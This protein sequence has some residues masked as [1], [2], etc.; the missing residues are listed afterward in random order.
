MRNRI[1][2]V[3]LIVISII[4]VAFGIHAKQTQEVRNCVVQTYVTTPDDSLFPDTKN[5]KSLADHLRVAL[6]QEQSATTRMVQYR[7]SSDNQKAA[8][9]EL[10]EEMMKMIDQC[11]SEP[12][13]INV[14][15]D[16]N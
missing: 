2:I 13:C 7:A 8:Y 16:K 9:E 11:R 15:K 10:N 3:S 5:C 1:T 6:D 12:A 14:M 4:S